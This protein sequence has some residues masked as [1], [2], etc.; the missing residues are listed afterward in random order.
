MCEKNHLCCSHE[1]GAPCLE[2]RA[3]TYV[4]SDQQKAVQDRLARVIRDAMEN[5][6]RQS[7][8]YVA[9]YAAEAA[10]LALPDIVRE[11]G[12]VLSPRYAAGKSELSIGGQPVGVFKSVTYKP[13]KFRTAVCEACGVVRF[14]SGL[15]RLSSGRLV[16][17]DFARCADRLH[18]RLGYHGP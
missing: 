7:P 18:G 8:T 12:L 16:C 13:L 3:V 17:R 5:A 4:R 14:A 2:K 11:L 6:Q 9:S 15:T 1:V 10:R